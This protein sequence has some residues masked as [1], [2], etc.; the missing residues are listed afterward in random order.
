MET[1]V[2]GSYGAD[3]GCRFTF[4]SST[5]K[6]LWRIVRAPNPTSHSVKNSACKRAQKGKLIIGCSPFASRSRPSTPGLWT[7]VGMVGSWATLDPIGQ[8]STSSWQLL[9]KSISTQ[10]HP[11]FCHQQHLVSS[12]FFTPL[13]FDPNLHGF[14]SDMMV[15]NSQ[16]F[17]PSLKIPRVS[18][19]L[20][21]FH[22]CDSKLTRFSRRADNERRTKPFQLKVVLLEGGRLLTHRLVEPG[23]RFHRRLGKDFLRIVGASGRLKYFISLTESSLLSL[24]SIF[25]YLDR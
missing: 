6:T 13:K 20:F 19:V 1:G 14:G 24:D 3:L 23:F 9:Q 12:T 17:A 22:L 8:F 10:G 11:P 15:T 2:I 18:A 16:S 25:A 5:L 21:P 4:S 7:L